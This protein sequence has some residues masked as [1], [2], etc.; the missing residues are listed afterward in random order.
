MPRPYD[1]HAETH[2]HLV[3]GLE[4]GLADHPDAPVLSVLDMRP[5]RVGGW[6]D[7]M[8]I[9]VAMTVWSPGDTVIVN[10]RVSD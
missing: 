3:A 7:A 10:R 4:R 6:C 2:P 9:E 1:A 5:I 8:R